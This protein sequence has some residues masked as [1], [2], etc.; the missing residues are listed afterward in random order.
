MDFSQT[1]GV[2]D[3]ETTLT[4]RFRDSVRDAFLLSTSE[5]EEEEKH[6]APFAANSPKGKKR[7]KRE[8]LF[9]ANS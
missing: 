9:T 7:N 3:I 4:L 8:V 2:N 5:G 1:E 6:G